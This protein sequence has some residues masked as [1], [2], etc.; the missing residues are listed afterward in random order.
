MQPTYVPARPAI[1]TWTFPLIKLA[2]TGFAQFACILLGNVAHHQG[3]KPLL[4]FFLLS[5]GKPV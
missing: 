2:L 1:L 3:N 4:R 5:S